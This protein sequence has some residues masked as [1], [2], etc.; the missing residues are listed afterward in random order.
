[1]T[2]A[3]VTQKINI[4]DGCFTSDEGNEVIDAMI[5]GKSNFHKVKR[6]QQ[7]LGNCNG[8]TKEAK[9][10][11][12]E[13]TLEQEKAR[14]FFAEAKRTGRKVIIKGRLELSFEK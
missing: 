3:E 5:E 13:L 11:T 14:A 9:H 2:S 4:V 7:W 10:R 12:Q 1:M 6:L 8:E